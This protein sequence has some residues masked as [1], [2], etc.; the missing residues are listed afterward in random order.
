M[1]ETFLLNFIHESLQFVEVT[2][3]KCCC[4]LFAWA[5]GAVLVDGGQRQLRAVVGAG[6]AGRR[7]AVAARTCPCQKKERSAAGFVGS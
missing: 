4:R 3:R 7:A 5:G 1:F 2:F 6:V